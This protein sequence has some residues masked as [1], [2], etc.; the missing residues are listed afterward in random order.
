MNLKLEQILRHQLVAKVKR[1][2]CKY[3]MD[4]EF[5]LS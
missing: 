3:G 1:F 5:E 4:K 2:V